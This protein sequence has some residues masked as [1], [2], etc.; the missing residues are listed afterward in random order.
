MTYVI[1]YKSA[2]DIFIKRKFKEG[3][4]DTLKNWL[5]QSVKMASKK[6]IEKAYSIDP[7]ID[8]FKLK[9][10]DRNKLGEIVSTPNSDWL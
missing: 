2:E 7:K 1:E 8:P 6:V 4:K 3:L 5:D 9:W 10:P